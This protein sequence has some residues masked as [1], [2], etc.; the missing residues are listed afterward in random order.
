MPNE[1]DMADNELMDDLN[2]LLSDEP[3]TPASP[4]EDPTKQYSERLKKDREKIRSEERENLAKQLGYDSYEKLRDAHVENSLLDKGLDPDTVK[5]LLKDLMKNDPEYLEAMRF[6]AEKEELEK[7]MWAT[8][9]I[10]KLNDKFGL[11]LQSVS[12]LDEDTVKLW[13]NG[14]NLE[15]AYAV[16]HYEE[17]EKSKLRKRK[18][19]DS[20]K[21]HL[22]SVEGN[23]AETDE[24]VVTDD[25]YRQFKAFNPDVTRDEVKKYLNRGK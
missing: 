21:N 17:I 10:K 8:D 19:Q 2:D 22:K 1:K 3:K 12:D 13:N 6:K 25:I 4:T 14:V 18:E 15:K 16:N 11:S 24:I 5:P 7:N 23:G 20:G 9:Q